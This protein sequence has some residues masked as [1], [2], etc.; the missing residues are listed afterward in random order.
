MTDK[1]IDNVKIS[2][3][4]DK[5]VLNYYKTKK[6]WFDTIVT[7][8][9]GLFCATGAFLLFKYGFQPAP[10]ITILIGL[11]FGFVT[12]MQTASGISS[13]FHPTDLLTIDKTAGR[14][15]IKQSV[16][17]SKSLL[18]T[19][20]DI[21]VITGHKE[22]LLYSGGSMTRIYCCINIKLKDKSEVNLLTINTDRFLKSSDQKMETELYLKSKRL[23]AELCGYLML[24]YKWTGYNDVSKKI[25]GAKKSSR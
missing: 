7:I 24:K 8:S 1:R 19:D 10:Y 25:D 12:I 21:L 6:D 11:I 18:I 15:L 17:K 4:T 20:T 23:T 3:S 22:D 16:F 14:L 5:V 2:D 9:I 13:L